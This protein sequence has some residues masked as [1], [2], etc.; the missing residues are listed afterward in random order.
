MASTLKTRYRRLLPRDHATAMIRRLIARAKD[1]VG[2]VS[3][4]LVRRLAPSRRSS[5]RGT[6]ATPVGSV[7]RR[8]SPLFLGIGLA[9]TLLATITALIA[10]TPGDQADPSGSIEDRALVAELHNISLRMRD[11]VLKLRRDGDSDAAVLYRRLAAEAVDHRDR[12][13]LRLTGLPAREALTSLDEAMESHRRAFGELERVIAVIGANPSEG[14]NGTVVAAA[15]VLEQSIA[16]IDRDD[17]MVWFLLMR[18]H[19]REFLLTGNTDLVGRVQEAGLNINFEI[20]RADMPDARRTAVLQ[21]LTDYTNAVASLSDAI[22]RR[23]TALAQLVL[24]GE[25]MVEP[26]DF[27]AS[28]TDRALQLSMREAAETSGRAATIAWI[29]ALFGAIG[30][31][32]LALRIAVGTGLAASPSGR[33]PAADDGYDTEDED[34]FAPDFDADDLGG[35]RATAGAPKPPETD[36]PAEGLHARRLSVRIPPQTIVLPP[37][38][39]PTPFE[40]NDRTSEQ[41]G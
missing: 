22:Q 16:S 2:S 1:L 13:R 39:D 7:G 3:A 17:L 24:H 21:R 14:L 33:A 10:A 11:Q 32:A 20:A 40:H 26:F 41:D 15:N 19:E 36:D 29:A 30:C 37:E 12:L 18:L 38:S 25:R 23:R 31:L 5:R 9:A 8:L 4:T 28:H 35:D 27:L 6:G 34:G